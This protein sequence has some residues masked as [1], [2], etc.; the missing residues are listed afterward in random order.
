[1][2]SIKKTIVSAALAIFCAA[3]FAKETPV[4]GLNEYRLENGLTLFTLEDHNVPLA[5][6]EI[7]FKTGA[8]DATPETAGLLYVYEYL[9]MRGNALYPTADEMQD[10]LSDMGVAEWNGSTNVDYTNFSIT[11]PSGELER[12]LAFW[13][14]AVRTPNVQEI[15]NSVF[16]K[17]LSMRVEKAKSDP[18]YQYNNYS[19]LRL[20]P[21]APYRTNPAGS[22][23][24]IKNASVARMNDLQGKFLIPKNAALFVGGDIEPDRVYE[25]VKRIYGDWSN[26]STSLQS[27]EPVEFTLPKNQKQNPAPFD[28]TQFAVMPYQAAN[29]DYAQISIK[30]RGPDTDF[31]LE[32]TYVADYLCSLVLDPDGVF[33]KTLCSNASL[34]IPGTDYVDCTYVTRR[35]DGVIEITAFVKNPAKDV[36]ARAAEFLEQTRKVF[37]DI[38]LNP[39]LFERDFVREKA[40]ALVD[41]DTIMGETAQGKLATLRFWWACASSDYYYTYKEKL[42]SVTHEDAKAFIEKYI[43]GKNPLVSVVLM[44]SF[45]EKQKDEFERKGF[46]LITGKNSFW[47]DDARYAANAVNKLELRRSMPVDVYYPR[48]DAGAV[49]FASSESKQVKKY[50]LKNGIPLYVQH[51]P[52]SDIDTISI[53]VKGGL[54]EFTSESSGLADATL[55]LAGRSSKNY[56]EQE[57][58]TAFYKYSSSIQVQTESLGNAISLTVIDS[59]W[60]DALPLLTDSFLYPDFNEETYNSFYEKLSLEAGKETTSN[61]LSL[62]EYTSAYSGHPFESM[63]SVTLQSLNSITLQNIRKTHEKMLNPSALFVVASGKIDG[64]E[65]LS[66]LNESLGCLEQKGPVF[67]AREIPDVELKS[68]NPFA[69]KCKKGEDVRLASLLF[70]F[71]SVTDKDYFT[72]RIA[73]VIYT[74]VLARV[75]RDHRV[76][77][78]T[79]RENVIS[80]K[81]SVAEDLFTGV[82]GLEYLNDAWEEACALMS[83]GMVVQSN[84]G[85][86]GY[87]F[88]DLAKIL[89]RYKNMFL[90][91]QYDTLST[92][93]A[94]AAMIV[95][96]IL[97]YDDENMEAK[98][99]KAIQQV[100]AEDVLRIFDN[101]WAKAPHRWFTAEPKESGDE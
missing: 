1:M 35:E 91:D 8:V 70:K 101:Y 11:V 43:H 42:S 19:S 39:A 49:P 17:K 65:L 51:N 99:I 73:S 80:S 68:A 85:E 76:A 45:Y 82:L 58:K 87:L 3:S 6:I 71:P 27:A 41:R 64:E 52:S 12:G 9:M 46:E 97:E 57:R 5:Y 33:K 61:L 24:V 2:T 34:D 4:Q 55:T 74:D 56:G 10:A 88:K 94:S 59:Y 28:S 69:M 16:R 60:K 23:S 32:D 83:L 100:T 14:A 96:N 98:K 72:A 77:C 29:E 81:A 92:S 95:K 63:P 79:V 86:K 44:P 26:K 21:D 93:Y 38:A 47:Q 78:R 48:K 25:L 89:P 36:P 67:S 30:F 84:H 18:S 20:F 62:A 7:A 13:N 53:A 66:V 31:D 75:A 54:P 40:R 90:A 37:D 22:E 50:S 15:D